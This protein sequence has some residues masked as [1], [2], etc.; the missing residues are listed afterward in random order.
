MLVS[1]LIS[2]I[3]LHAQNQNL[4]QM[5]AKTHILIF[6]ENPEQRRLRSLAKLA[7]KKP[8]A[9][10]LSTPARQGE[11]EKSSTKT[12]IDLIS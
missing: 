12:P 7:G 1:G 11:W 5:K 6:Y 3:F 9:K 4:C 2:L 10:R 8:P